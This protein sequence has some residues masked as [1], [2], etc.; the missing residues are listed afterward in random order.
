MTAR[1]PPRTDNPFLKHMEPGPRSDGFV[2]L[3]E[4]EREH[5]QAGVEEYQYQI[6]ILSPAP[7]PAADIAPTGL[8]PYRHT[9]GTSPANDDPEVIL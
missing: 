5:A 3:T 7:R 6:G 8:S 2:G 4:A 9:A 1:R